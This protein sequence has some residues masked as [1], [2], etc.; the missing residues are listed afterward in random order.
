[1]VMYLCKCVYVC[2]CVRMHVCV[3]AVHSFKHHQYSIQLFMHTGHSSPL[4]IPLGSSWH[5]LHIHCH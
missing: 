3:C 1:M 4:E 2:V 5:L